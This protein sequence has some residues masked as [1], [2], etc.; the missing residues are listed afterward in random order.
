V[1]LTPLVWVVD[2]S[3]T[4]VEAIRRSL[5]VAC[6]VEVFSN[7]EVLLESL[8]Q[9]GLPDVV[10]LDWHLPGLSGIEISRYLRGNPSTAT[11]PILLLTSNTRPEDVEEGLLAGANDYVFKPFRPAE[12][13][14]RVHALSRWELQRR[15][16]LADERAKRVRAED[17][18]HEVQSAEERARHSEQ[19]YQ[20]AARATR[21]VI[22]EWNPITG[23]VL[24]SPSFE[25]YFG[26]A[27]QDVGERFEWWTEQLHPEDRERILPDLW[28]TMSG[29]AE[30]WRGEYRLRRADGTWA[31]VVNRCLIVRDAGGRAIQ[32]V[33]AL[34]DVTER[35]RLEAEARQ[36]AEFER[37]LIGIVSHDLRNPL[38][39]IILAAG[40]L[41][42][43]ET[44]EERHR[45]NA[46]RVLTSAE[47]A[48][49][50]IRDLLDFTQ[51]RQGGG[52]P[53]SRREAHLH[54]LVHT[55]LDEVQATHPE[56]TLLVEQSGDGTGEWDPDRLAQV[57]S[58]LLGNAIQYSPPDTPVKVTTRGEVDAVVLEVHN[59]GAPIAPEVLG[60]IFEP[61]ERGT[62]M[63]AGSTGR[64]IGLGLF[65]VRQIVLAHGGRVSVR[66][67]VDEGTTFTVLLPRK[68]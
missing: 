2:D 61:M 58:N 40:V 20:L 56:R 25:T 24:A 60:R 13:L 42:K 54:E 14:A 12:L 47:R 33:G 37:Q 10:V 18:L 38:N 30:E 26:Y 50:L 28:E 59:T 57:I 41:L 31:Q 3:P 63:Q 32:V 29:K 8:Q 9:Q 4:E 45:R 17:S 68:A 19:R 15:R 6:R 27:Q 66:S 16:S 65:I 7:G 23:A 21:D 67:L 62:R 44:L 46:I 5:V 52:I 48:T 34:Q 36:R 35:K 22:W 51:A 49:R 43:S 11:L 1:D 55:V 53:L 64:S 39:A